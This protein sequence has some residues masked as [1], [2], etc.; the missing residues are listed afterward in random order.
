MGLI[1]P[2]WIKELMRAITTNAQFMLWGNVYDSFPLQNEA[3]FKVLKLN[4]YLAEEF[5]GETYDLVLYFEP[6]YGLSMLHGDAENFKKATGEDYTEDK[7]L[8][9]TLVAFADIFEK[10]IANRDISIATIFNYSSRTHEACCSKVQNEFY[11]KIFR[12]LQY[13]TPKKAESAEYAR[14]NPF[15]FIYDKENDIPAWYITDNPK[16]KSIPIPKPDIYIRETIIKKLSKRIDGYRVMGEE[17]REN[18]ENL[19][20]EQ[21]NGLYVSEI[22]AIISL[23]VKEKVDFARIGKSITMYKL[24]II[25]NEWA[26]VPVKKLSECDSILKQRVMGQSAAV[27]K[28]SDILKRAYFNLSGSQ[29]SKNSNRPKGVMFFAGPTGV[30]KTEL[31]KAVTE[32]VFGS[33]NNYIRFDMSEFSQE[34]ANQRLVGAPPGYV[35]YETG[36]ELTNAVKENPFTVILFDE[37]EKAHPRIMDIFL[38]ILDDGRLTS[39]RGET[40]Y[41]SEVIIIFTSNLGVYELTEDNQKVKNISMDM[42]YKAISNSILHSINDHFKYSLQRPEILN[43]IGEN[44]VVFDYIRKEIAGDIFEKMLNSVCFNLAENHKIAI[45]FEGLTKDA[46]REAC[47]EDLEMGGRGIGNHL[48]NIFINPLSRTLFELNAQTNDTIIIKDIKHEESKWIIIA[49]KKS[50]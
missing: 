3:G 43:R 10:I 35:G 33:E 47:L 4:E 22:L 17:N 19:F 15:V 30:G 13:A 26:K 8:E 37:I 38:Q 12:L 20:V 9:M 6:L 46:I 50:I 32:L 2:K 7:P 11:Y 23:A 14:Y 42:D 29:Y 49:H 18:N 21:T 28:V 44:I 40:V 1:K 5:K 36:G 34:N 45:E 27:T 25:E 16:L 31:A 48:E 39:G 24:G 41:L